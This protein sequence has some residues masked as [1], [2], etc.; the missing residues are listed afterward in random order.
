[1]VNAI[2]YLPKFIRNAIMPTMLIPEIKNNL[3]KVQ[4][5][6]LAHVYFEHRDFKTF[7]NFAK[8][9]GLVEDKRSGDTIYFRGYGKDPYVYVATRSKDGKSRFLG[10]AFVAASQEEFDKAALI[11]GATV[12]SLDDAPGGGKMITIARPGDTFMHIVYGQEE[13]KIEEDRLPSAII[14]HQGPFNTPFEKPRLGIT[15]L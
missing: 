14:D 6:R 2:A 7:A 3:S 10:A 9:F 11:E 12:K 4:L 5:C 1:M 13:R 15:I 8:D